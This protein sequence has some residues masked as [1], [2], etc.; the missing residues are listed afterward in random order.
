MYQQI[1]QRKEFLFALACILLLMLSYQLALKKT[2]EAWIIHRE[3][4]ARFGLQDAA[5]IQPAYQK[6]KGDNLD[7]IIGFY[8]VDSLQIRDTIIN[9]IAL[10]AR[11]LNVELTLVPAADEEMRMENYNLQVL[12]FEGDYFSIVKFLARLQKTPNIG[13]MRSVILKSKRKETG[14]SMDQKIMLEIYLQGI[15]IR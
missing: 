13:F 8:R 5:V 15:N 9:R 1:I 7:K 10:D 6:R 3:L 14:H 11:K 12:N 2:Y 4:T